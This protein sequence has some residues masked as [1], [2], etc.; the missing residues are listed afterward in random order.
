MP[1][2]TAQV[3]QYS[4]IVDVSMDSTNDVNFADVTNYGHRVQVEVSRN[5]MNSFFRWKR[6]A[7]SARPV[8]M[9]GNSSELRAAILSALGT[10]YSDIDGVTGGLHFGSTALSANPDP[11][12]RKDG[13]ISS[14]DIPLAYVLY[15]L[16]GNSCAQTLDNVYN[17]GDAYGMLTNESVADAIIT[18]M[19]AAEGGALDSMFRDLLATDPRR[20]FLPSGRPVTGIFETNTDIAGSGSWL[21]VERD[22]IEVKLKLVFRSKITRRGVAGRQHNLTPS[23][24]NGAQQTIISPGDYFYIRLQLK[25]KE[26]GDSGDDPNLQY[27]PSDGTRIIGYNGVVPSALVIPEGVVAIGDAAF[28]NRITLQTLTLPSTLTSIGNE[29]FYG[30]SAL[31]TVNWPTSGQIAIGYAAFQLSGIAQMTFTSV[32]TTVAS[33]AFRQTGLSAIAIENPDLALVGTYQ[34]AGNSQLT[35]ITLSNGMRADLTAGIFANT[36]IT[37]ITIPASVTS[38]PS[39]CFMGCTALTSV[40]FLGD[41]PVIAADAFSGINPVPTLYYKAAAAGWSAVTGFPKATW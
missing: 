25:V 22:T 13:A 16:Y 33:D 2:A 29:S 38:I 1:P 39:N 10:G 28:K 24:N 5:K 32:E 23:G 4:D 34:F 20:F 8:A 12:I 37:T 18:S 3:L 26:M 11:R 19:V 30:C 31:T 7:G 17:L 27:D 14:N 35:N 6:V 36:S 40:Y 9:V 21:L 15:K 41:A